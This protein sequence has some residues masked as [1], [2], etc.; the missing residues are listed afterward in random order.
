MKTDV[1]AR[2]FVL[3]EALRAA[4]HRETVRLVQGLGRP[5][6]R[7]SVR[8]FDVNSARRGGLDKGCLVQ[9]QFADGMSVVGTDVGADL[10]QSVSDVFA[11]VLRAGRAR[12]ERRRARRLRHHLSFARRVVPA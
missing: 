8:L 11:K 3:T 5:I 12:M 10:Y 6:L 2:G 4:V 7:V 1:K 9:V